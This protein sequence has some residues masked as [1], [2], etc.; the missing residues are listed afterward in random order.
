MKIIDCNVGEVLLETQHLSV[1]VAEK[2]VCSHLNFIVKRG[3]C[4]GLLGCN[5]AGKT[6]L[7]HTLAGLRLP[8]AGTIK[9]QNQLLSAMSRRHIA[10]LVGVLFQHTKDT[11]PSTVQETTLIGRHPYLTAWRWESEEDHR[12][13]HQALALMDL[14]GLASRQ[15]DTLSGGERQR[16]AIAALLTQDPC[17]FLLDEPANHLDFHHQI[18]VMNIFM[19][20]VRQERKALVMVLHDV[21]MAMRYCD[22]ILLLLDDGQILSGETRAILTRENLE[23]LYKHP[24]HC[25]E[26]D[27][28]RIFIAE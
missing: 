22:Q 11:F 3:E 7:L 28:R 8:Q 24:M 26:M 10:Q 14:S 16:L 19:Q 6:T 18:M 12:H 21:N 1:T 13:V 25:I 9:L 20:K 17:L 23:K 4:W 2:S 27:G 5:G 15:A